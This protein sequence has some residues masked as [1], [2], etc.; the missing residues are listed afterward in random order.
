MGVDRADGNKFKISQ[1][2]TPGPGNGDLMT[3]LTTGFVGIGT[4][5]P[6]YALDVNGT[7]RGY[8]ITDSSD[9]RLKRDVKPL[10]DSLAR[11]TALQGVSYVWLD[12]AKGLGPQIGLI[13]QQVEAVYPELVQVDGEGLR[14][15]NYSH[16]V[17]PLIEAVKSLYAKLTSHDESL[18]EL[19]A[20][21]AR[22]KAA[23][24]AQ[25]LDLARKTHALS[26]VESRLDALEKKAVR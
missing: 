14:S 26:K 13:A 4:T 3:V 25:A 10:V 18:R 11:I 19:R 16:L 5:T 7:I 21:N 8:G 2:G 12:P 20:E 15:L 24:D 1:N 17:A 6:G 22:L 9:L 23:M